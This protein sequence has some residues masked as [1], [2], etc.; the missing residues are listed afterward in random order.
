MN[1]LGL[2]LALAGGRGALALTAFGIALG[3][4]VLLLA[5]TIDPAIQTRAER[6]AWRDPSVLAF[7]PDAIQTS[8]A[9]LDEGYGD[10]KLVRVLV[11]GSDPSAP[12]PPGI[13]ALPGP[14]S[15]Y[16]SPALA[17][18]VAT[19]PAGQ[20]GDRFGDMVGEIGD[21]ALAD[22]GELVAITGVARDDLANALGVS[23]FEAESGPPTLEGFLRTAFAIGIVGLLAPVA[24]FVATATRLSASRRAERFAAVRLVGASP[25]QARRLAAVEA[26]V[27]GSAGA[28]GGIVLFFL[29]RPVAAL[30]PFDGHRWFVD[31][32]TPDLVWAAAVVVLVPLVS[33][34]AALLGL[35]GALSAPLG[36]ARRSSRSSV[37]AA[38]L[39]PLLAAT[40]FLAASIAWEAGGGSGDPDTRL[41]VIGG[42]FL[43]L[44]GA[45]VWAGPYLVSLVAR[46]LHRNAS[47][48][49]TLIAARRLGAD[50]RGGFY[51]ISG[52]VL[53]VFIG[54]VFHALIVPIQ[55]S[56]DLV[57]G[58]GLRTSTVSA[59][60][61]NLFQVGADRIESVVG[62]LNAIEGVER[63][64]VERDVEVSLEGGHVVRALVMSCDDADAVLAFAVPACG[65]ADLLTPAEAIPIGT[66]ELTDVGIEP[67]STWTGT[68][69]IARVASMTVPAGTYF[70]ALLDP[71]AVAGVVEGIAPSRILVATD[72]ASA[73]IER[74]RTTIETALPATL[75]LSGSDDAALRYS[76][77]DELGWLI[78]FGLVAVMLVAGSS[79]AMAVIG[80]L[81]ER[82]RP[83]GLL[84]LSGMPMSQMRRMVF[85]EAVGPLVL[86]SL[87]AALAGVGVAQ[88]IA[89]LG[90]AADPGLPGLSIFIPVGI[91]IGGGLLVVLAVLPFLERATD[92]DAT[93]FE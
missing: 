1:R 31:D 72:G 26:F 59:I 49:A 19:Q 28:L 4:G 57:A 38:R 90:R 80:G 27:A 92:S 87:T 66:H 46:I 54:S 58:G 43:L 78:N 35:R 37:S 67:G 2:R 20:L 52:V 25:A 81:I 48:P 13:P 47:Q 17:D 75:V 44:V 79:L 22:P 10:R 16:L 21:V 7:D 55:S 5:L 11:A 14:G 84:R 41:I 36:A 3:T 68:I 40:G 8:V 63:V 64:V 39:V 18:L 73:T 42:S 29:F 23:S 91:G 69:T 30:L 51:A 6:L 33:V 15:S 89:R 83:L 50:P 82:R 53:A 62:A 65:T 56:T 34:G 24:I 9:Y 32:L 76:V 60:E 71:A 93:R 74:V 45:L 85:I 86:A 70:P 88:L 61:V 77:F 12:I